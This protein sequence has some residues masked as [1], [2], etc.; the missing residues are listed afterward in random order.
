MNKE[1]TRIELAL[2]RIWRREYSGVNPAIAI[3]WAGEYARKEGVTFADALEYTADTL[4]RGE[5]LPL[6]TYS[7][8]LQ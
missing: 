4:E 1:E 8:A 6:L 7:E 3:N 5:R 2:V